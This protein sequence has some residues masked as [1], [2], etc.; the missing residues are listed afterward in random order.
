M[1]GHDNDTIN[2]VA[3]NVLYT[4]VMCVAH[5]TLCTT[6]L[7]DVSDHLTTCANTLA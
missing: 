3:E 6:Q 1:I 7:T 4:M 5:Y 2:E